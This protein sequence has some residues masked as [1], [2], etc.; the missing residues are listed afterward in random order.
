[1]SNILQHLFYV[2]V[3]LAKNRDGNL[4]HQKIFNN[5]IFISMN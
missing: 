4:F 2:K 3:F 5:D 1:M